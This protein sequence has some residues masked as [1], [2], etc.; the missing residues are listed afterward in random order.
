[1][2]RY[3]NGVPLKVFLSI[4]RFADNDLGSPSLEGF[5]SPDGVLH[6]L[7]AELYS[8]VYPTLSEGLSDE[9]PK[10][11]VREV[12][13]EATPSTSGSRPVSRA[14]RSW[15]AMS[16]FSKIDQEDINRMRARYQI[17]DDVVLRIPDLDKRACCPKYE[18][19]VAFYEVDFQPC[20]IALSH[21]FW[22]FKHR[23]METRIV[24]GLPS[25]NRSWKDDYIFVCGD[26]WEGL[27]RKESSRD[28][29]KVCRPEPNTTVKALLRA[30]KKRANTM[31]LNKGKLR[32][33]AQSGEV[34]AAPVSLKCKKVDKGP[35]KQVEQSSSRLPIRDAIPLVKAVPP[36]I[37]VD[38]DPSLPADPSKMKDATIN[39]STHVAMSR[40]KSAVSSRDVDNYSTAHTEDVHYLLIHSLMRGLNEAMV[41]SQRFITVEEDLTTFR[42][43]LTK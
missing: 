6:R 3:A 31:K 34:V 2:C 7:V 28:F 16:Y 22:T 9:L 10:R 41:M 40:A 24:H 39:Q 36:V 19:D 37:M 8:I 12:S 30:N 42:A 14:N 20:Q 25:S 27:P 15:K 13:S 5:V 43:K 17:P 32:K 1:M 38:V 23:D 21:G 26:N 29:V 35:L 33:F 4:F 11:E 18:G